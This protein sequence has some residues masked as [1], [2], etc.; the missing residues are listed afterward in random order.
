MQGR[1]KSRALAGLILASLA[2]PVL[3]APN[4]P[5]ERN[6]DGRQVPTYGGAAQHYGDPRRAHR[7]TA[8]VTVPPSFF[9]GS[10][11][12]GAQPSYAQTPGYAQTYVF[13]GVAYPRAHAATGAFA[14]ASAHAVSQVQ[15]LVDGH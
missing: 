15:V 4:P 6:A 11:G 13:Y 1:M 3:A 7:R 14:N 9:Y 5:H 10:G 8:A 2:G 12:V